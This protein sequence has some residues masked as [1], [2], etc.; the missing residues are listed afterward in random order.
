MGHP[1]DWENELS[2]AYDCYADQLFRLSYAMLLSREDAEDAVHEVF[3]KYLHKRPVF[4]D[5]EHE[6]AWLLRVG[7]NQCR[8]LLRRRKHRT[9]LPLEEAAQFCQETG[10]SEVTQAVLEL[11]QKQK[12]VI[13]LHYYEGYCVEEIAQMLLISVS[14]VKMRLL[15]ARG[16]LHDLLSPDIFGEE[17]TP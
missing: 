11:E 15:R 4:S 10:C 7:V 8:D 5:A 9:H 2:R 17:D 1:S 12:E 3:I 6:K 13:L 16:A 14:A